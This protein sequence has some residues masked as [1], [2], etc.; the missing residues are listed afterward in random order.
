VPPRKA[1]DPIDLPEPPAAVETDP[2]IT[3]L[4]AS[5]LWML[6][7]PLDHKDRNMLFANCIRFLTLK[8][9]IEGTDDGGSFFGSD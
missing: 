7:Q 4:E 5:M 2:F 6:G 1:V 8:Y 9:K 3:K